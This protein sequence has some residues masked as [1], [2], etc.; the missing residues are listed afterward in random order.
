MNITSEFTVCNVCANPGDIKQ[1]KE[2]CKIHS[3]IAK[4]RDKSFTVWRCINCQSIH[5]LESVDL[6]YYYSGYPGTLTDSEMTLEDWETMELLPFEKVMS[7]NRIAI[8]KSLKNLSKNAEILDY[9]CNKGSFVMYLRKLGYKNAWGYDPYHNLFNDQKILERQYDAI[10]TQDVIEHVVDPKIMMSQLNALLKPN[11][12]LIIGTPNATEI[13]LSR[14]ELDY[15]FELHQPYHRHILSENALI[16]LG[17]DLGLTL[18]FIK[19]R[20]PGD[21]KIPFINSNYVANYVNEKNNVFDD[22]MQGYI[23]WKATLSNPKLVTL[24]LIGYWLRRPG[25]MMVV[26]SK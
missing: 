14:G 24:G 21:T 7:N 25:Q 11:G 9:G 2:I 6:D 13:N 1:A 22:I 12:I 26:F 19:K 18:K 17:N 4:F 10:F 15:N 20:A 23:D 3:N 5:S 8:I 16:K